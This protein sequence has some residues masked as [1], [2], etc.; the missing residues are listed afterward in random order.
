L[1]RR[2]DP[3][4]YGLLL[5][6][7]VRRLHHCTAVDDGTGPDFG[8][9]TICRIDPKW[10]TKLKHHIPKE[11]NNLLLIRSLEKHDHANEEKENI[12]K[13]IEE[14]EWGNNCV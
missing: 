2:Q 5:L 13:H 6:L 12:W 3:A 8:H 11:F 4:N 1:W 10:N 7:L 14:P 9:I